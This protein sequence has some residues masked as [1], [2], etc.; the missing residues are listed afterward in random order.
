MTK[1]YEKYE[2]LIKSRK[3]TEQELISFRKF[4]NGSS[5]LS[6]HDAQ[7]LIDWF[8]AVAQNK[9]IILT[10]EQQSKGLEWLLRNTFKVNGDERK[11]APLGEAEQYVVRNFKK[12]V[13]V[14]L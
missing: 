6:A 5:N 3:F 9:G 12:F 11:N 1:T 10:K 2:S 4:V 8:D 7:C 13:C 14:G